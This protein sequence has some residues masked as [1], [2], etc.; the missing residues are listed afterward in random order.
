MTRLVIWA[1]AIC[2][3]TK[4]LDLLPEHSMLK[5]SHMYEELYDICKSIVKRMAP[6]EYK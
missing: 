4:K 2:N 6:K 1:E 5:D 3:F